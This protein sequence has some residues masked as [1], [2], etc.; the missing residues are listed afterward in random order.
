MVTSKE[1][2]SSA[3][4]KEAKAKQ[5]VDQVLDSRF[6][7]KCDDVV[8]ITESLVCVLRIVDSE[9]KPA[10]GILYKSIV[11]ARK[12]M[13]RRFQRNKKKV[14]PYLK[15]LDKRWDSQ[16]RKNL[17]AVD[18]MRI[19]KDGELYFGRKSAVDERCIVREDQ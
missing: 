18:E 12:D 11:K 9:D 19:F 6:W 2:T 15:I 1:W 10:M 5:F 3:Y 7:S 13:V 14:D 4:A 16:F 17:H 8:K